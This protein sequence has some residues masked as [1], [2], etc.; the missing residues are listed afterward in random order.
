MT[1]RRASPL[2]VVLLT[3]VNLAVLLANFWLSSRHETSVTETAR[4]IAEQRGVVWLREPLG[5]DRFGAGPS[6]SERTVVGT[7]AAL[8]ENEF[9]RLVEAVLVEDRVRARVSALRQAMERLQERGELSPLSDASRSRIVALSRHVAAE[10]ARL[11]RRLLAEDSPSLASWD[12]QI[13]THD[14]RVRD[15]ARRE[16]QGIVTPSEAEHLLR[17]IVPLRQSVATVR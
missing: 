12:L 10:R 3:W 14:D 7:T 13:D 17:F 1:E 2:S 11:E 4:S 15:D 8:D 5:I 16:L 9:E 6:E